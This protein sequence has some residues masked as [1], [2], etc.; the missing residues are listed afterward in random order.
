MPAPLILAAILA[1]GC[2]LSSSS[3][4]QSTV[5]GRGVRDAISSPQRTVGSYIEAITNSDGN[6]MCGVVDG[7]LRQA[8]IAFAVRNRFATANAQ[9]PEALTKL[10]S[11]IT[12][13][14]ER[15]NHEKLPTFHVKITGDRAVVRYVGSASHQPRTIVLVKQTFGWLIDKINGNG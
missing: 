12:A 11:A 14:G 5:I 10:A 6:E 8:L 3:P 7:S 9:C 2:G 13:P 1:A 4:P 15:H